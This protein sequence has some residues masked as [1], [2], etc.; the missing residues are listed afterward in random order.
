MSRRLRA[1][2]QALA[3]PTCGAIAGF[4]PTC[5]SPWA[6]QVPPG[7]WPVPCRAES[8]CPHCSTDLVVR[9]KGWGDPSPDCPSN[10]RP[11]PERTAASRLE[12]AYKLPAAQRIAPPPPPPSPPARSQQ[13][14]PCPADAPRQ[15]LSEWQARGWVAAD[16]NPATVAA[17]FRRAFG[18]DPARCRVAGSGPDHGCR[19][20]GLSLGALGLAFE[21]FPLQVV[22]AGA[23]ARIGPPLTQ[24]LLRSHARLERLDGDTALVAAD[25][26][27]M[28]VV[29][30]RAVLLERVLSDQVGVPIRVQLQEVAS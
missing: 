28:P 9:V 26:A 18:R 13:A 1:E 6:L 10:R 15:R 7:R 27:L 17:G 21:P 8:S 12:Q 14:K 29:Q 23:L 2:L 25:P 4:C 16:L 5:G 24:N 3:C 11:A 20:L 22:W 30:S 19:E